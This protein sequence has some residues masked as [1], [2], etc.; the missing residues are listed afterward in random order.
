MQLLIIPIILALGGFWFSAQQNQ[1]SLQVAADQQQESTLETYLDRMSGFLLDRNLSKSQPGDQV[2][3]LAKAET[4]ITLRRLDP[5]RKGILLEFLYESGLI[6]R[7]NV[8]VD[9]SGADLSEAKITGEIDTSS[10]RSID[11]RGALLWNA[12]LSYAILPGADLEYANL[13]SADLTGVNLVG[14]NL[15]NANLTNAILS[16]TSLD[17][18]NLKGATM[19][20]GSKHE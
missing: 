13:T 18:A 19:P 17:Y 16:D 10:A 15:S 8:I 14:A 4:F 20:D 3:A 6:F 2:R 12:N 11:I 5:S 1:T 9:L 7:N